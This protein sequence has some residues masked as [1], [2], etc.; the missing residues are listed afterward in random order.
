MNPRQERNYR[1]VGS[2]VVVGEMIYAPTRK[3][4]L[5][6]LRAGGIAEELSSAEIQ[7]GFRF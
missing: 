1:I 2:P 3:T 5:F 7:L 4:P 6:A